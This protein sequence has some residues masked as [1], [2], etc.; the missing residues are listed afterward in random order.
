MDSNKHR[1]I[2]CIV[3]AVLI[4]AAGCS[5][6]EE[7]V[8]YNINGTWNIALTNT[9]DETEVWQITFTGGDTGGTATDTYP[10]G[11]GIGNYTRTVNQ[12]NMTM[13]YMGGAI[14]VTYNGSITR[15]NYMNGSWVSSGGPSGTWLATR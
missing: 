1:W 10:I 5:T 6:T 11:G 15:A 8:A 9:A 2:Y 3:F 13:T 4:L 14:T 7:V 12:I